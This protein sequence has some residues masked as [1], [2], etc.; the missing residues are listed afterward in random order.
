MNENINIQPVEVVKTCVKVYMSIDNFQLNA[1]N[2]F[3]TVRKL[4]SSDF[5]IDIVSVFINDEEYSQ[6]SYQDDYIINL[7]LNKLGLVRDELLVET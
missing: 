1:K 4:D 2:C 3:V 7:V 6:W 5:L